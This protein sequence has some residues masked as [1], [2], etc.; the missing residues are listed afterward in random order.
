M[1]QRGVRNLI[2][3]VDFIV[4]FLLLFGGL[5]LAIHGEFPNPGANELAGILSAFL[6][7]ALFLSASR[8]VRSATPRFRWITYVLAIAGISAL[9]VSEY[10]KANPPISS[11]DISAWA[12]AS[13]VLVGCSLLSRVLKPSRME[14]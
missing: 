7:L 1:S 3:I 11:R 4:G 10:L 2:A 14:Q 8:L 13:T 9:L 5:N 12:L 6:G